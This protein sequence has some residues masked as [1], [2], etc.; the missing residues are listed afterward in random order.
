MN[1]DWMLPRRALNWI[2]E[3]IPHSSTIIELGSGDGSKELAEKY[4]VHSIEHDSEWLNLYDVSYIHAPIVENEVSTKYGEIGWYDP[5]PIKSNLPKN[6][7]LIIIDGPPGS[8]GRSGILSHLELFD[9]SIPVLIDDIDRQ[10]EFR[11]SQEI[12]NQLSLV[13]QHRGFEQN[14]ENNRRREFAVFVPRDKYQAGCNSN[15]TE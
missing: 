1:F 7:S 5:Q 15:G 13:C 8:I 10:A 2:Y 3:N 11:I 6:A 12:S 4:D 9:W 14:K